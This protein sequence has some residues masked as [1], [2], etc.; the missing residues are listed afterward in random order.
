[1][2]YYNFILNIIPVLLRL[3]SKSIHKH[4]LVNTLILLVIPRT[5]TEIVSYTLEINPEI[6]KSSGY[7]HHGVS[8][9]LLK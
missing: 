6:N 9:T 4:K 1:M 7:V 3:P 5:R 8:T 2:V